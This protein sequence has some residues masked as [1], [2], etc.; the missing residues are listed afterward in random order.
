MITTLFALLCAVFLF[1]SSAIQVNTTYLP[2]LGVIMTLFSM[3]M[4]LTTPLLFTGAM[5]PLQRSSQQ[6]TPR[7]MELFKSDSALGWARAWLFI[8]PFATILIVFDLFIIGTYSQTLLLSLWIVLFGLSF[9][10][11]GL[12]LKRIISYQ[13]PDFVVSMCGQ[14]AKRAIQDDHELDLCRWIDSL[15]EI[16]N[17]ALESH[18]PSLAN[19]AI[20]ELPGIIK[21]F[22][23][24]SRSVAH[25][26]PDKQ[27][28]ELG[29]SDK[30]GYTLFFTFQRLEV[31]YD[32]AVKN[33]FEP[34]CSNIIANLGKMAIACAQLEFS[35]A[36]YPIIFIGKFAKKEFQPSTHDLQLK[37][38]YTLL[39]VGKSIIQDTDTSYG[40][41]KDPFLS[42]ITQMEA[43]A[44]EIFRLNKDINIS[45]LTQPFKDL[46]DL[47]KQE[48]VAKHPDVPIILQNIN[49][50]LAEF[51]A[52]EMV[53]RTIPPIPSDNIDEPKEEQ[54]ETT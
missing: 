13:N 6:L 34:I 29:I 26:T 3:A 12:I 27:A 30:I 37:A 28:K 40:D 11:I 49:N 20:N 33:K 24:A 5:G 45:F 23:D 2:Y 4:A 16:G 18:S 43:L 36:S 15:G 31:L 10:A 54:K 7:L 35:L 52:L 17:K 8:F 44:K 14:E 46:R 41:L 19:E 48:K 25:S 51:D 39:E 53:M 22:L 42:I 9:D 50:V 47:F 21:V 32:K 1:F 38:S